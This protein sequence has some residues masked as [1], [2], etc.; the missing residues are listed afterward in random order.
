MNR[1]DND[2]P[3]YDNLIIGDVYLMEFD[4]VGSEQ[5]GIR[6]GVV[7]QN[8]VGNAHSP[9]VIALPL[10]T[11]MK[12]RGLPTHVVL[13][14]KKYGLPYDSMVLCENPQRMSRQKIIKKITRL[15]DDAMRAIAMASALASASIGFLS[16]DELMST[17]KRAKKLNG[18]YS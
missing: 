6:P 12:R 4:G 15:D 5:S 11:S 8:N 13:S 18:I 7:F 14:A 9:N 1:K 2:R 3:V 17:W 10:T 16:Y